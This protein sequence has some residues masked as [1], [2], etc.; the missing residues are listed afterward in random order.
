MSICN[1]FQITQKKI[2]NKRDK[3]IKNINN[4]AELL[5]E[6]DK[7]F[8]E[9]WRKEN[10]K[11]SLKWGA[12]CASV[13][14]AKKQATRN[15]ET[16]NE[17]LLTS[18]SIHSIALTSTSSSPILQP[19]ILTHSTG[20]SAPPNPCSRT[21]SHCNQLVP[22][23]SSLPSNTQ[24]LSVVTSTI[25][26]STF[27]SD[28]SNR[29][30]SNSQSTFTTLPS[31]SPDSSHLNTFSLPLNAF[32]S[33]FEQVGQSEPRVS[34]PVNKF[35]SENILPRQVLQENPPLLEDIKTRI[36]KLEVKM[37][38]VLAN[39]Q[40]IIDILKTS[41][42]LIDHTTGDDNGD[43]IQY[44]STGVGQQSVLV[45]EVELTIAELEKLK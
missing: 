19:L 42:T 38:T 21:F 40:K 20:L 17:S 18:G 12:E 41:G 15:P 27:L 24:P 37:D 9:N 34:T 32:S 26:Y 25:P 13:Q 5:T 11:T 8:A 3:I 14:Q 36:D 35:F 16:S 10:K 39:Q 44:A 22:V 1:F 2:E 29:S 31:F 30:P 4:L 23:S 33:S 7:V 6:Q 43:A 28:L 45:D